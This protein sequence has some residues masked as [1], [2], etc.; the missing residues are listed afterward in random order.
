MLVNRHILWEFPPHS[1]THTTLLFLAAVSS[2][3]NVKEEEKFRGRS[4]R[5]QMAT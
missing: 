1:S 5:R 3:K 4:R 2:K